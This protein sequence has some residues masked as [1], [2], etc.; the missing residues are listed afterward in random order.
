[1]SLLNDEIRKDRSFN[2]VINKKKLDA[3][4]SRQQ[5]LILLPVL[6]LPSANVQV[7]LDTY[8]CDVQVEYVLMVEKLDEMRSQVDICPAHLPALNE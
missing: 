3:T 7:T 5:N 2:F 4:K 8:G 6:A 1:M